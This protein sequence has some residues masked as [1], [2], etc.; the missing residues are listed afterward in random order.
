MAIASVDRLIECL[1]HAP[2]VV[3]QKTP[4]KWSAGL[5]NQLTKVDLCQRCNYDSTMA[6][7]EVRVE[8]IHG[9]RQVYL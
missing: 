2:M 4:T 7:S 9:L 1:I 6:G 5:E 8:Y 3:I